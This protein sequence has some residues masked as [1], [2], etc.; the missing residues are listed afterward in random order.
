MVNIL[1]Q[2]KVVYGNEFSVLI[3]RI[4]WGIL[5]GSS[6]SLLLVLGFDIPLD[7]YSISFNFISY[8]SLGYFAKDSL[9]YVNHLSPFRCFFTWDPVWISLSLFIG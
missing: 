7:S 9:H 2:I 5:V 6:L 1:V 8:L 3:F 4:A